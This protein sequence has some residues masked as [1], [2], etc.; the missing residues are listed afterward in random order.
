MRNKILAAL[1]TIAVAFVLAVPAAHADAFDFTSQG[2][3]ANTNLGS[4]VTITSGGGLTIDVSAWMNPSNASADVFF[5]S[6]GVGE[7]GLGVAGDQLGN[8]E[9]SSNDY[10]SFDMSDLVANGL[11]SATF[12]IGSLQTGESFFVCTSSTADSLGNC[13]G[14][15][16]GDG[17]NNGITSI[18]VTWTAN[19]PFVHIIG[20][21]NDVL[22]ASG[23]EVPEA[24]TLALLGIGLLSIVGPIRRRIIA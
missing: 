16:V 13:V 5:K 24:G 21:Q 8:N 14:P 15:T 4:P 18:N 6:A 1:A 23:I 17:S 2:W 19:D 3:T 10:L 12:E 22:V 20:G 11:Y 9:I 7:T